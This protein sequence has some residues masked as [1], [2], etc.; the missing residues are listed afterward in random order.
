[1]LVMDTA[2]IEMYECFN[3]MRCLQLAAVLLSSGH[4]HLILSLM[5]ENIHFVNRAGESTSLSAAFLSPMLV[6]TVLGLKIIKNYIIWPPPNLQTRVMN[7][8]SRQNYARKMIISPIIC[9]TEKTSFEI[10]VLCIV[11]WTSHQFRKMRFGYMLTLVFSTTKIGVK[12]T[13]DW[14]R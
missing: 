13:K 4:G 8:G 5:F 9:D 6:I 7:K 1:M 12:V 3:P 2:L 14:F 10:C 11:F